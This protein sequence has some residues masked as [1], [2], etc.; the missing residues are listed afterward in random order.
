[1]IHLSMEI[2]TRWLLKV[3]IYTDILR[4]Y[5][6]P[7]TIFFQQT[8]WRPFPHILPVSYSLRI[9]KRELITA[10]KK[11]KKLHAMY[12]YYPLCVFDCYVYLC[13][14]VLIQTIKM[15]E[16]KSCFS[17][18]NPLELLRPLQ[19]LYRGVINLI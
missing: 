7:N 1:M 13:K 3:Y 4:A 10:D 8:L 11:K 14:Y 2:C 19:R 18:V 15:F 17:T 12:T 9:P 6:T 5:T 16:I